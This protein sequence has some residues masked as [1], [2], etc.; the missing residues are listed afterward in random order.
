MRY[1]GVSQVVRGDAAAAGAGSS[2]MMTSA[3]LSGSL[4]SSR[5]SLLLSFIMGRCWILSLLLLLLLFASL[6]FFMPSY[7]SEIGLLPSPWML[8]LATVSL[9]VVLVMI[10]DVSLQTPSRAVLPFPQALLR[11]S[12]SLAGW[13]YPISPMPPSLQ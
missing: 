8:L 9:A 3:G 10:M 11:S 6:L 1:W 5:I 7:P 13:N 12:A 4:S 2:S